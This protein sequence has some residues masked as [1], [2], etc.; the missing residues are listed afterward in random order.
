MRRERGTT[1]LELLVAVSL[2]SLVSL[3]V[4]YS[5]RVGLDAMDTTNRRFTR[6]R[7]VLGV[8]RALG[9][10][11][12]G[13]VP[14]TTECMGAS[15]VPSGKSILFHGDP[16]AMRFVSTYS[17][18]EGARGMPKLLEFAIIPGANNEGV[19]IVVNE[20]PYASTMSARGICGGMSTDPETG[21][22]G[23]AYVPVQAGAGSFVIADRLASARF[24]YRETMP[25][26]LFERWRARWISTQWPSA[27]RVEMTPLDTNPANL[28]VMTTTIPIRLTVN[29]LAEYVD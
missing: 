21:T 18:E 8:D 20:R 12:A 19:R 4:L 15:G 13:L 27:I 24:L 9:A 7:R 6:N 11:I 29:P 2:V 22:A 5:M 16:G 14:A 26:P 10:Q 23:P 25:A 17:L 1:L 3:G 28:H